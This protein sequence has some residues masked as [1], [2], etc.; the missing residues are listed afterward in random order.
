MSIPEE[1]RLA[2][3][4][5][6]ITEYSCENTPQRDVIWRNAI[7]ENVTF[8]G[9]CLRK[10]NELRITLHGKISKYCCSS[11]KTSVVE[12]CVG[13]KRNWDR[14]S[15]SG[16]QHDCLTGSNIIF[17]T[18][19][20]LFLRGRIQSFEQSAVKSRNNRFYWNQATL[21]AAAA[22]RTAISVTTKSNTLNYHQEVSRC[23]TRDE[24]E[25]STAT[26]WGNMH[27]RDL[28]WLWNPGQTS[29]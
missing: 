3:Y 21:V 1:L 6:S 28:P 12:F 25:E 5:L 13:R 22:A 20:H 14:H 24:S 26:R 18:I 16:V 4:W 10:D 8:Y 29:P 7:S 17:E 2:G 27:T 15:W 9:F 19:L 23:R 11:S